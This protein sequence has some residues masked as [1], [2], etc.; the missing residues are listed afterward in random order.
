M[1]KNK[2]CIYIAAHAYFHPG[3]HGLHHESGEGTVQVHLDSQSLGADVRKR[4]GV[5]TVS[6]YIETIIAT[7]SV[8]ST[9]EGSVCE[10][11]CV[12]VYR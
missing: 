8:T 11:V 1:L 9:L 12:C 10:C 4:G 7:S 2:S 3:F 6:T 5:G